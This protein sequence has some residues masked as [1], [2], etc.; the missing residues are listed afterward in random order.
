MKVWALVWLGTT[1]VV[2]ATSAMNL[3]EAFCVFL[4]FVRYC[5]PGHD[6]LLRNFARLGKRS[7]SLERRLNLGAQ[8]RSVRPKE[9]RGGGGKHLRETAG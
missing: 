1:G 9:P 2:G 6:D 5:N 3:E 7:S 4:D 8:G